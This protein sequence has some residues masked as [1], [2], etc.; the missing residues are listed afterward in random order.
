[1]CFNSMSLGMPPWLPLTSC[2]LESHS[3]LTSS[4]S[5]CSVRTRGLCEPLTDGKAEFEHGPL[6]PGPG[7]CI[8]LPA[9]PAPYFLLPS[10]PAEHLRSPF[11]S[12]VCS[13]AVS[14][15]PFHFPSAHLTWCGDCT[16]GWV[17]TEVTAPL[18]PKAGSPTL[19]LVMVNTPLRP[20]LMCE[21]VTH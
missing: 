3:D 20:S 6:Q 8:C 15:P 12:P 4:Q 5:P 16:L 19:D 9:S 13:L 7:R 17:S 21:A 11:L 14:L 10:L 18:Q 1:M 2:D